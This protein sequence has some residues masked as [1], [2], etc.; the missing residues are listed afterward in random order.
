MTQDN[1]LD[2]PFPIS[3]EGLIAA[4]DTAI[5]LLPRYGDKAWDSKPDGCRIDVDFAAAFLE[6]LKMN[7]ETAELYENAIT[8]YPGVVR[9]PH[10]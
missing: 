6:K 10:D 8:N 3:K 4:L 9:K 7:I 2:T 1:G 5:D